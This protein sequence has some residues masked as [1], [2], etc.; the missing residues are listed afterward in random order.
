MENTILITMALQNVV[1]P[2][3]KEGVRENLCVWEIVWW[4]IE[5]MGNGAMSE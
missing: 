5:R 4:E 1:D 3:K 2:K